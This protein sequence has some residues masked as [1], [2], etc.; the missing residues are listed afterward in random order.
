M[1]MHYDN[2]DIGDIG[3]GQFTMDSVT[4]GQ[5]VIEI[6]HHQNHCKQIMMMI[7]IYL[8]ERD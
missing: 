8:L 3:D 7:N 5:V 4:M 2:D 6:D 1:V